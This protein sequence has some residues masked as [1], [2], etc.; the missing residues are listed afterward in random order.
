MVPPLKGFKLEE[1]A[2]AAGNFAMTDFFKRAR[3]GLRRG[4]IRQVTPSMFR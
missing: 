1:A 3:P 2:Q 4:E